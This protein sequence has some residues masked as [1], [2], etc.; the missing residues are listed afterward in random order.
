MRRIQARF[1]NLYALAKR[2]AKN[3]QQPHL[4]IDDIRYRDFKLLGPQD[5]VVAPNSKDGLVGGFRYGANRRGCMWTGTRPVLGK[6]I[7]RFYFSGCGI[8]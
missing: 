1:Y 4:L 8:E 2:K 7:H 6:G 3:L 5:F